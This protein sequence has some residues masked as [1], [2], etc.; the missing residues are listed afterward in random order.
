MAT[1]KPKSACLITER[2]SGPCCNCRAWTEKVHLTEPDN[3]NESPRI[4]C[5]ECC[6]KCGAKRAA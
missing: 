3:P 5:A 4:Y 6:L 2:V 1:S